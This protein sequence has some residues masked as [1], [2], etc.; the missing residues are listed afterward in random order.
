MHQWLEAL[1]LFCELTAAER[2]RAA[3]RAAAKKQRLAASRSDKMANALA[4]PAATQNSAEDCGEDSA[5]AQETSQG[6]GVHGPEERLIGDEI[7]AGN[8][9][10]EVGVLKQSTA[11]SDAFSMSS[12]RA[13]VGQ[14][15]PRSAIPSYGRQ[16]SATIAAIRPTPARPARPATAL[17]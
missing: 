6:F 13:T 15:Q 2:A 5:Q 1:N 3:K 4:L 14:L 12:P 9:A 10:D 16:A 17:R 11:R 8:Q 7:G